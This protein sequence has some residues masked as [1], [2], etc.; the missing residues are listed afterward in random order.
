MVGSG[1]IRIGQGI[2]FDY[3]CVHAAWALRE[4]G[5]SPVVINNNPETVSTDFDI[6]DVLIFEP[7]GADEVEAAYRATNA[8]G[9]ML[10]FGGQTAINLA[11]A[12][13]RR[14]V[15]IIGSDRA[16][17]DMAEDRESSTRR[18]RG[19]ASRGRRAGPRRT[20][21]EARAIAR[22]LGFPVLV[23]PS[24]VL[25]GRG[26][27]IVY[28]RSQLQRYLE[29][30]M[31][32]LPAEG[33]RRRGAVL[34]DRYLFGT[35]VDVDAISDGETVVIPGL[36]EHVERA[37]VHSGNSMAAYPARFLG[38][39]VRR[40]HRRRDDPHHT[41]PRCSRSVQHSVRGAPRH[42]S[43]ARGQSAGVADGTLPEQGDGCSDGGAGH[44]R[45]ARRHAC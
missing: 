40:T 11:D 33:G 38:D 43:R 8:R 7:P 3:S 32:A 16:S 25:G 15:T 27:E 14:G 17:L 9:V 24:Y 6:S 19:W 45:D 42:S 20:F 35:E 21:R 41:C 30:A 26:M 22:E 2:E 28:S 4:A 12:L 29:A 36:M 5:C 31:A 1:P 39:D 37:G 34:I 13:A 18:S 23:R 44:S 10:A